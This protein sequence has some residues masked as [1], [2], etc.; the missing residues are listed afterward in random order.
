MGSLEAMR[1]GSAARYGHAKEDLAHK[2]TA[3]GVEALKEVAGPVQETLDT[4]VGGIRSG[5]GYIGASDL[6]AVRE[7][8]RFLRVSPA[9]QREASTH[10]IVEV[11]RGDLGRS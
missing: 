6:Q 7:K 5:L 10:D 2:T 3:E 11:K 9:G 4:L 1:D 8:A